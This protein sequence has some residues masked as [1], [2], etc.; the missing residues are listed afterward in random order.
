MFCRITLKSLVKTAKQ[1]QTVFE[2]EKGMS[3]ISIIW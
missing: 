2:Q 3:D 1:Q